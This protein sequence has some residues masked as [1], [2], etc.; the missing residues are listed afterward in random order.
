M[1]PIQRI[2]SIF[3][4]EDRSGRATNSYVRNIERAEK[5]TGKAR[6]STGKRGSRISSIPEVEKTLSNQMRNI[7][8]TFEKESSLPKNRFQESSLK[9]EREQQRRFQRINEQQSTKSLESLRG[10]SSVSKN[11]AQAKKGTSQFTNQIKG[12]AKLWLDSVRRSA[13]V[14]QEASRRANSISS[15]GRKKEFAKLKQGISNI[16]QVIDRLDKAIEGKSLSKSTGALRKKASGVGGDAIRRVTDSVKGISSGVSKASSNFT[17]GASKAGKLI[18]DGSLALEKGVQ[19]GAEKFYSR[20]I[21]A[22]RQFSQAVKA[23]EAAQRNT[24]VAAPSQI[25]P[26]ASMEQL[27]FDQQASRQQQAFAQTQAKTDLA[28][29]LRNVSLVNDRDTKLG[30]IRYQRDLSQ[31]MDR[32]RATQREELKGAEKGTKR[33][34]KNMHKAQIADQKFSDKERLINF[35]HEKRINKERLLNTQKRQKLDL[36]NGHKLARNEL[37]NQQKVERQ[38]IAGLHK[39]AQTRE[40]QRQ[41]DTQQKMRDTQRSDQQRQRT[42]QREE[43]RAQRARQKAAKPAGGSRGG[44]AMGGFA[45]MKQGG[46][47]EN[48]SSGTQGLMTAMSLAEGNVMGLAFSLIFLQFASNKTLAVMNALIGT[49]VLL[50]GYAIAGALA[51]GK[52]FDRTGR[53]IAGMTQNWDDNRQSTLEAIG[54]AQQYGGEIEEN[55][56]ALQELARGGYRDVTA[57]DAKALQSIALLTGES[58]S[59]VAAK[60]V[61]MKKDAKPFFQLLA[62][63]RLGDKTLWD[64]MPEKYGDSVEEFFKKFKSGEITQEDFIKGSE[65]LGRVAGETGNKL[66]KSFGGLDRLMEKFAGDIA[67]AKFGLFE[68]IEPGA[69]RFFEGLRD[70]FD[71]FS[72]SL[73]SAAPMI[74]MFAIAVGDF[75]VS[76]VQRGVSMVKSLIS[77]VGGL[78]GRFKEFIDMLISAKPEIDFDISDLVGDKMNAKLNAIKDRIVEAIKNGTDGWGLALAGAFWLATG[79][80]K[81]FKGAFAL[82]ALAFFGDDLAAFFFTEEQREAVLAKLKEKVASWGDDMGFIMAGFLIT[83]LTKGIT[84][85]FALG[86][87]AAHMTKEIFGA[88]TDGLVISQDDP[89]LKAKTETIANAVENAASAAIFAKFMGKS[90]FVVGLAAAIAGGISLAAGAITENDPAIMPAMDGLAIGVGVT[91]AAAL[92]PGIAAKAGAMA[93]S[94]GSAI[95]GAFVTVG[96]KAGMVA[97]APLKALTGMVTG[98]GISIGTAISAKAAVWSASMATGI[99]GAFK[100]AFTRIGII[101]GLILAAP[102]KALTGMVSGVGF[103]IGSAITN[104]A[105]PWTKSFSTKMGSIIKGSFVAVGTKAGIIM[106]VPLKALSGMVAGMGFTIGSTIVSNSALWIKSFSTKMGL[107][108]AAS[109]ARIA[110]ASGVVFGPMISAISA[111]WSGITVTFLRG[112]A[113]FALSSAAA[114]L[115]IAAIIAGIFVITRKLWEGSSENL[116]F[117]EG[118]RT[119]MSETVRGMAE[120]WVLTHEEV[121]PGMIQALKL[122]GNMLH[123]AF[124]ANITHPLQQAITFGTIGTKRAFYNF[125]K[126][127][128]D[129]WNSIIGKFS[130]IPSD[131]PLGIGA[132]ASKIK[133]LK[134]SRGSGSKDTSSSSI[135]ASGDYQSLLRRQ[136]ED[137]KLLSAESTLIGYGRDP[138]LRESFAAILDSLKDPITGP[139]GEIGGK[140]TRPSILNPSQSVIDEVVSGISLQGI[141]DSIADILPDFESDIPIPGGEPGSGNTVYEDWLKR[142]QLSQQADRA[143]NPNWNSAGAVSGDP[144]SYSQPSAPTYNININLPDGST[145]ITQDAIDHIVNEVGGQMNDQVFRSGGSYLPPVGSQS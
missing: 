38:R 42:A 85:K 101:S 54:M 125:K 87:L 34:L 24:G 134:I 110:V 55:H 21:E 122:S 64:A 138:K 71:D 56:K 47:F 67:K 28:Q 96:T 72:G 17:R 30:K 14:S 39:E 135:M 61:D 98:I 66:D 95:K 123:R 60:F 50:P 22:G 83:S 111:L 45:G 7:Q 46:V 84:R 15:E 132:I 143:I 92:G 26:P 145:I 23:R 75:L 3:E 40:L 104:S 78:A 58:I 133:G 90:A 57:E 10:P 80:K 81:T 91:L 86:V 137:L 100:G 43:Q 115:A 114:A 70:I 120:E 82:L 49:V 2:R 44:G 25:R 20:I 9:M 52:E 27:G 76:A 16:P 89:E 4:A 69:I 41:R 129:A 63:S 33:D 35:D 73:Q 36:D 51:M 105:V 102:L 19:T 117:K 128:I 119:D 103:S 121:M 37:A 108:L 109:Y 8:K 94:I 112:I 93:T 130:G 141:F 68:M 140:S 29:K 126:V 139:D 32:L 97:L 6:R 13:K 1:P 11:L 5:A 65:I 144:I 131:A 53:E 136:A 113:I 124:T 142:H 107:I 74:T 106:S 59:S 99:G 116:A 31:D 127:I 18:S 118:F 62:D 79:W 48:L 12:S 77:F 88:I